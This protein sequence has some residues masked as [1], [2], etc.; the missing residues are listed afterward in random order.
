MFN[1]HTDWL[2]TI[3]ELRTVGERDRDPPNCFQYRGRRR[4]RPQ[5]LI[6]SVA[7]LARNR[8]WDVVGTPDGFNGS[9]GQRNINK[10][11]HRSDQGSDHGR[12]RGYARAPGKAQKNDP[13]DARSVAIA[14]LRTE[15]LARVG[16]D[17]HDQVLKLLAKRHRDLA[18]S[19]AMTACRLHALLM[20]LQPGG[21]AKRMSV[22]RANDILDQISIDT[23]MIEHRI[24]VAR[25]F[26]ADL[27]HYEH[28]MDTSKTRLRGAVAATSTSLTDI[29]G[30][31]VVTAAMIIGHV[32]NVER[33]ASAAHFA[34]YNGTAPIEA[35]SGERRRHRLNS[36]GKPPAELCNPR[37][38]HRST[39]LSGARP[40]LSPTQTRRG[41]EH[42]RSHPG[43]E[44]P[45]LQRGLPRARRRRPT[46]RRMI[47]WVR[48]DT[49]ARL[50]IQR[51]RLNILNGRLFGS[52]TSRTH[53]QFYDATSGHARGSTS[54]ARGHPEIST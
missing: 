50:Q 15:G 54:R 19:R 46:T 33:F 48:E 17:E 23:E 43:V 34:S 29:R 30:I 45:D 10:G 20:E 40:E 52:V 1:L 8:D 32:G 27:V 22:T 26:V 5:R 31:G 51:D 37:R 47:R 53:N 12:A 6:L 28:Q 11:A 2:G 41:Q 39:P 14:V 18:R 16:V 49:Q 13:N 21:M 25:E 42:Q 35:S 38:C 9:S 44:T 4:S 36:R 24:G 3:K 7:P